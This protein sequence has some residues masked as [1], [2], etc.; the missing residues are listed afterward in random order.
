MACGGDPRLAAQP[1]P[2][3][4]APA[5]ATDAGADRSFGETREE[6]QVQCN[7]LVA[8]LNAVVARMEAAVADPPDPS[9][10]RELE[11]IAAAMELAAEVV[12]RLRLRDE[13]LVRLGAEYV[14]MARSV[15]HAARRMIQAVGAEDV[16]AAEAAGR[17]MDG[18]T[19]LEDALVDEL[20]GYC[21][22]L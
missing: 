12:P 4:P 1:A 14:Y 9:G 22:G 20:N 3:A 13:E 21:Q 7:A 5:A 19:G 8:L 2:T 10:V 16:A 11:G 18:A 6:K 15:A 17:D